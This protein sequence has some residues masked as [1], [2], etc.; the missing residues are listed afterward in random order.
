MHSMPANVSDCLTRGWCCFLIFIHNNL[1]SQL[2]V[3]PRVFF[4]FKVKRSKN[5]R[6]F[7][8]V[9]RKNVRPRLSLRLLGI[10][11]EK[12]AEG[13]SIMLVR[14]STNCG[15]ED[16]S[17]WE[18]TKRH[19]A[20]TYRNMC[21]I[22]EAIVSVWPPTEYDFYGHFPLKLKCFLWIEISFANAIIFH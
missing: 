3:K 15:L 6:C 1:C 18:K 12:E 5:W 14:D 13:P 17:F 8:C 16:F 4:F 19:L 2:S 21:R 9:S 10:N 20:V 22:L 7:T 11:R